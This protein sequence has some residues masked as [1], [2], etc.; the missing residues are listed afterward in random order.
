MDEDK[1]VTASDVLFN[2]VYQI[3][4]DVIHATY[5]LVE[6]ISKFENMFRA[7]SK[8]LD[9]INSNLHK[10]VIKPKWIK[11]ADRTR[12]KGKIDQSKELMAIC[13]EYAASC[14][15]TAEELI[16]ITERFEANK[17]VRDIIKNMVNKIEQE[18]QKLK[19]DGKG[20]TGGKDNGQ[21]GTED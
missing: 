21:N 6:D 14:R 2:N 12:C 1:R 19:E 8:K 10:H 5:K 13:E 18:T 3:S 4:E 17:K 20:Y 16:A 7:M 9:G 11:P 15:D